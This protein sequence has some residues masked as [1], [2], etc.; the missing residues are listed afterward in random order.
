MAA[1]MFWALTCGFFF[2]VAL[3]SFFHIGS[4]VCVAILLLAGVFF[5]LGYVRRIPTLL[6]I[7]CMMC[8]GVLGALRMDATWIVPDPVLTQY[9][10]EKVEI[11]GVVIRDPDIRDRSVRTVI[12]INRIQRDESATETMARVLAILPA[13][14]DVAYGDRVHVTGTIRKPRAFE[15][16]EGRSFN[17]PLFL[18]S[19]G[20]THEI[21]FAQAELIERGTGNAI[22]SAALFIK[23]A[24]LRGLHAT[25]P[26]PYAGLASGITVGDK[27][28]VGSEL[29][30]TFQRV[31][32]THMLV[33]SG[34]NITIVLTALSAIVLARATPWSR[35]GATIV[36]AIFFYLISGGAATAVRAGAMACIA[37]YARTSGRLFE[38]L[39]VL[40]LVG[41]A[42]V[43][44]NPYLLGFDPGFQLSMLATAGLI[45][46]TP[47]VSARLAFVSERWGIR[48]IAASSIATQITVL[49]LLLYQTGLLSI[50]GLPANIL[51]LIAVPFAMAF[52]A[53]AALAGIFFGT[54]GVI[55]A[56]PAYVLLAYIVRVA[57]LFGNIP[58]AAVQI[59]AFSGWWVTAAYAAIMGAAFFVYKKETPAEREAPQA[60]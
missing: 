29:S 60:R 9:E 40:M 2:G 39:R 27:R 53:L 30:E 6:V 4:I 38:A 14:S 41:C 28:S 26:E 23:H 43:V 54:Y 12:E 5:M 11:E 42:M 31:S 51:A 47:W 18:E 7:A 46:F 44:W 24:Y 36:V 22:Q 59:A 21:A 1:H 48:E 16:G 37:V 8:A 58:F 45:L 15:S 20:I 49:P 10:G 17:Y 57:E 55:A 56:F 19:T 50:V 3:V 33:L 32:L 13:H 25:L 35:L 52:S 34:Y